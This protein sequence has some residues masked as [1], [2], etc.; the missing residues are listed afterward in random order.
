MEVLQKWLNQKGDGAATALAA[1][2]TGLGYDPEAV[3]SACA[4][5][6]L[7]QEVAEIAP[8]LASLKS[9]GVDLEA[10]AT[11]KIAADEAA[12]VL[13]GEAGGQTVRGGE[14]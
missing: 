5:E 13:P 2:L 9:R 11:E 6:S 1:I 3:Q 7:A 12:K 4:A 8:R 10:V 14:S